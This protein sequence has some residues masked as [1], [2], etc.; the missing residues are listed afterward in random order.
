MHRPSSPPQASPGVLELANMQHQRFAHTLEL[1]V[2]FGKTL[3][4]QEVDAIP[5]ILFPLLR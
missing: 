5:P 3:V 4:V 2:R 1:A